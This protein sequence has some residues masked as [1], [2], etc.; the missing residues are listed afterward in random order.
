MRPLLRADSAVSTETAI[1]FVDRALG[2]NPFVTW[3]A[4]RQTPDAVVINLGTN[5]FS[6]D[7]FP[8]EEK[9]ITAYV[10]LLGAVRARYPEAVI[11]AVSGPLM[12]GPAHRVIGRSMVV[13]GIN[14]D[15]Q[16]R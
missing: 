8:E 1:D 10:D 12:L 11:F 9:F 3:P 7:P 15:A 13:R 5:D 16:A 6:S 4:E 14:R 2:L